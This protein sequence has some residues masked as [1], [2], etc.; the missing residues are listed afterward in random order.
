MNRSK[1]AILVIILIVLVGSLGYL[2]YL[3]Q[4][5]DDPLT[6]FNLRAK[7]EEDDLTDPLLAQGE[8]PTPTVSFTS[9]SP[10]ISAGA[11]SITPSVSITGSLSPSPASSPTISPTASPTPTVEA[12]MTITP[13]PTQIVQLPVSGITDYLN[14]SILGGVAL[15]LLA[16]LL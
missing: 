1:I 10:T 15:I 13:T 16:F 8:T 12:V 2:T 5:G 11:T 9:T 7:N 4:N 14:M 3:V 6:L